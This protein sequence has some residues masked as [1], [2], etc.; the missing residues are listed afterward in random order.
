MFECHMR[1]DV[2]NSDNGRRKTVISFQKFRHKCAL[3]IDF[4]RVGSEWRHIG[5]TF[6]TSN[7]S[8]NLRKSEIN[9]ARTERFQMS[10]SE[11]AKSTEFIFL[12]CERHCTI[13]EKAYRKRTVNACDAENGTMFHI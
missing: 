4:G 10:H 2:L 8:L 7:A 1:R 6:D 5:D 13:G 3:L 9:S 12:D 11:P